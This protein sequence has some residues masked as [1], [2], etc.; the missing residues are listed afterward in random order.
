NC[1]GGPSH[2][3]P[4]FEGLYG[5]NEVLGKRRL[6]A[7]PVA[8]EECSEVLHEIGDL[9][10][11]VHDLFPVFAIEFDLLCT[12]SKYGTFLTREEV[13]FNKL[14]D[15]SNASFFTFA[16]GSGGCPVGRGGGDP[17]PLLES[18]VTS[19]DAEAKC[20]LPAEVLLG[21]SSDGH[22]DLRRIPKILDEFGEVVMVVGVVPV[23]PELAVEMTRPSANDHV[24]GRN[25]YS[26]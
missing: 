10:E 21:T 26:T 15:I 4:H 20:T 18:A 3:P 22:G 6:I 2:V 13:S 12:Q 19:G 14:V 9:D 17:R 24:T 5:T 8:L 1:D 23:E 11:I 7:Y 25:F 16:S